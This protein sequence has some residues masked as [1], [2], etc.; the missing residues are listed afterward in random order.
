VSTSGRNVPGHPLDPEQHARISAQ[1]IRSGLKGTRAVEKPTAIIIAGQPGAGKS[2]LTEG[3]LTD[4]K[5][6]GAV[7]VDVDEYRPKHPMYRDLARKDD[8]TAASLVQHDA[9]LWADELRDA[10]IAERRN[11]IIDGTLKS[12]ERAEELCRTLKRAGYRVEVRAM[13]VDRQTSLLGI[14]KRYERAKAELGAGRWV[15]EGGV[16]D[17]AY[18][19]MPQ[20][21]AR[22]EKGGLADRIAVYGRQTDDRETGILYDTAREKNAEPSA[23]AAIRAERA[24]ARTA[25][26]QAQLV[27]GWSEVIER[28]EKRGAPLA[29]PETRRAYELARKAGVPMKPRSAGRDKK[30]NSPSHSKVR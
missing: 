20:A 6:A 11:L 23:F 30:L 1:I 2:R 8:R 7:T 27:E 26:E 17:P 24:R 18:R 25:E 29:E 15:P 22:I 16:H 13:A 21:I 9:S 3:A 28:T 5:E 14:H 10:A 12:P 19:G 4:L